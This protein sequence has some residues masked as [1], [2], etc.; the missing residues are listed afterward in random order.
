MLNTHTLMVT[1]RMI[2][3]MVYHNYAMISLVCVDIAMKVLIAWI[4]T[5]V[6]VIEDFIKGE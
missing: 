5:I 3:F 2:E 4:L 1:T 6:W